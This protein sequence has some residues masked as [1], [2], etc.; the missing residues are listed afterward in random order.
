MSDAEAAA[1]EARPHFRACISLRRFDD[2]GK[3]PQ[4]KTADIESYEP[5]I[6]RFL[7]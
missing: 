6:R 7:K 1:F 2:M 5:L 4:M 3:V